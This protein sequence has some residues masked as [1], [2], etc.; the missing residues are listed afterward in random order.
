MTIMTARQVK[1]SRTP[2]DWESLSGS[3]SGSSP[4]H[5]LADHVK[6]RNDLAV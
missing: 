2:P 4:K 5:W 6:S 1:G 3:T